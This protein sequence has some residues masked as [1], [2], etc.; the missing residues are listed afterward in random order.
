MFYVF[1]EIVVDF[2]VATASS[3][4]GSATGSDIGKFRLNQEDLWKRRLFEEGI[5]K[6]QSQERCS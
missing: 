1:G 5:L 2:L 3:A 6:Y 4:A